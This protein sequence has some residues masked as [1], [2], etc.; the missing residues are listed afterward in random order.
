VPDGFVKFY[1]E[2]SLI[3]QAAK[4]SLVQSLQEQ[5]TSSIE[6]IVIVA[7][8]KVD[9]RQ[10]SIEA[11]KAAARIN[12]EQFLLWRFFLPKNGNAVTLFYSESPALLQIRYGRFLRLK[13]RTAGIN[14]GS[15]YAQLQQ[16]KS[17]DGRYDL[18]VIAQKIQTAMSEVHLP[19]YR[20]F[21]YLFVTVLDDELVPLTVIPQFE[22]WDGMSSIAALPLY[23]ALI[24]LSP[25]YVV[26]TIVLI[27]CVVIIFALLTPVFA[28]FGTKYEMPDGGI[29]YQATG[30][31]GC[32]VYLGCFLV[33]LI[34]V[35]PMFGF[36]SISANSRAEDLLMSQAL[37]LGRTFSVPEQVDW[38]W[39]LLLL[40]AT[41]VGKYAPLTLVSEVDDWE[42]CKSVL[43]S[44]LLTPVAF[45]VLPAWVVIFY[46]CAVV[47][48]GIFAIVARLRW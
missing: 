10:L 12:K 37:G 36:L 21:T 27:G 1:D 22:L 42:L 23:N 40:L 25:N 14:S 2:E 18:Q 46:S 8:S 26:F 38:G 5:S 32:L 13:A 39:I 9:P 3:P 28:R 6:H 45:F 43:K 20:S 7:A 44:L 33:L 11:D 47:W 30:G 29:H 41:W 35:Y 24:C 19:F 48:V 17:A 4:D 15:R 34:V 31:V 16:L